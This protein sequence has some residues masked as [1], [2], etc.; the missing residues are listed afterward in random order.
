MQPRI[1]IIDDDR[2][3]IRMWSRLLKNDFE[4]MGA[5]SGSEGI[6]CTREQQ[7]DVV[8]LDLMMPVMNGW[9]VCREIRRFS[10]VPIIIYSGLG[11]IE[12]R[13]SI[14]AAGANY[15]LT[16]PAS[17]NQILMTVQESIRESL[18]R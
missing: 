18:P 4:V 2:E 15:F 7:P 1:L 14:L 13:E 17:I 5:T 8:I 6:Q 16:K 11:D 10:N 9:Q 12:T 3:L